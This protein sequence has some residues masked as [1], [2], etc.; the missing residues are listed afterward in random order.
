M[1]E[2]ICYV[3]GVNIYA[4]ARVALERLQRLAYKDLPQLRV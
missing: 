2:T 1:P 3:A 4:V